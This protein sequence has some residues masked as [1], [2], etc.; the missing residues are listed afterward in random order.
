MPMIGRAG[1]SILELR[2]KPGATPVLVGAGRGDTRPL[3]IPIPRHDATGPH[4]WSSPPR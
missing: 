4:C 3:A 1:L 2:S